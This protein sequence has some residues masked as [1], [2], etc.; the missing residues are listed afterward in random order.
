MLLIHLSIIL[1]SLYLGINP[2][3]GEIA[4]IKNPSWKEVP[5]T[6]PVNPHITICVQS[7][8]TVSISGMLNSVD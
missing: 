6:K 4:E 3:K 5:G 7:L 1:N 8:D 2:A